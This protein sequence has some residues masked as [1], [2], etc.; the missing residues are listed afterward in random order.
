MSAEEINN[1]GKKVPLGKVCS[2]CNSP[3]GSAGAPK[4]SAC[5]R[6]GLAVY[7]SR[8]CQRDHWK[9]GHK[10]HC[11]TKAERVPQKQEPLR[12]DGVFETAVTA[13][14]ECSICLDSMSKASSCTLS[15]GHMFHISCMAE[16]RHM[17]LNK[18]CPLCRTSLT[19]GPQKLFY[20]ALGRY[21]VVQRMVEQGQVSWSALSAS[22]QRDVDV[23]VATW[24][25][26]ADQGDEEAQM[27]LGSLFDEGRGVV[28]NGAEAIRWY[29]K[30]AN[31][32]STKA[33]VCV[34]DIYEAGRGVPQ[35]GEE[36]IRYYKK[37]AGLGHTR[38]LVFISHMY[39]KGRG[40]APNIVEAARWLKKA[41]EKG[42]AQA[43]LNFG[44]M[45]ASG[46]GV[47][48]STEEAAQWW[49]KA[50]RQGK[51]HAQFNLG[52]WYLNG[53]GVTQSDDEAVRWYMQAAGSGYA[54]AQCNLGK[55]FEAGR[56]VK[57][58]YEKAAKWFR[59]AADQGNGE[60]QNNLG[61]LHAEGNGVEQSV[62][63]ALRWYKKA[64]D[65]GIP[66]AQMNLQR[67]MDHIARST[68]SNSGGGGPKNS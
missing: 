62:P 7:C 12:K 36:A 38:A 55:L 39:E 58:S 1:K 28:R 14:T 11:V 56:G 68:A 16:V 2:N 31:Q 44:I 13:G 64:A 53:T 29:T 67:W 37:A 60:A 5:A 42:D 26:A 46:R 19:A 15:C 65:Q 54:D 47:E 3:Q 43:Q 24:R 27:T 50:A 17:G 10:K 51:A 23:A 45:C 18:V 25:T 63:E 22:A 34:G 6:C 52:V 49:H 8:E 30:A 32:G 20:E 61:K 21:M 33:L 40:V 48:Q 4:L 41:A 9:G 35:D 57:Q 59:K 66:E